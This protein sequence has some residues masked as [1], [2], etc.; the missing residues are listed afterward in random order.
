MS[1]Q[2]LA[3]LR[4]LQPYAPNATGSNGGLTSNYSQSGIGG[5]NSDQWDARGDWQ[6]SGRTHVFGRFSRFTDTLTGTTIFGPAGGAGF[7]LGGYGGTS[8]GANDSAAAG[9]DVALS[10]KWVT[11]VRLG[12][13]RYGITTSKYDQNVAFA[14]QLGIPG[15]NTGSNFTSG[16]PSFGITDANSFGSPGGVQYGS[17][18]GVN[19]CNCALA[20]HEDQYQLANNWTR[21]LGNHSIKFGADLRYAR[22]LR[23]PSDNNRTGELRFG[24]GPTGAGN[25]N[26]GLGLATFVLGDVT[27]F[28]RYASTT[29]NAKEFQKRVFFYAQD[30]WRASAKLTMNYGLRYEMYF[31]EVVNGK[32]N[33]ALLNLA[34]GYLQVA[35]YGSYG[36]NM[37]QS[38]AKNTYNPRIGIAYQINDKTVFRAGYGRSFDIG[39]FG[40]IFGHSAT[41]NLPVL[42]NQSLGNDNATNVAYAFNLATGPTAPPVTSV[43]S[44]GNLPNPGNLVSSRSRPTTL[45]LP[46]LDAWN[47]SLQQSLTPTLSMTIAYVGNKGTH[48]FGDASSNTTNPNESAISLPAAYSVTGQ[49][50]HYDPTVSATTTAGGYLGVAA[51]GGTA[52]QVLLQR[53]YGG[54]LAACSDPAYAA[55][56]GVLAANGGCGWTQ[57]VTYFGD[58]LDTHYNALQATLTKTMAHGI[59]LNANY[60]WQQA[61]SEASGFSTWSRRAVRGN[62]SALRRQQVIVYGLFQLPFGRNKAV[63]GNAKGFVNQ[64][65]SGFEIN[66]VINYSSGLPFTITSNQSGTWVPGSAPGYV[67]G[68]ASNFQ[69]KV[70]GTPNGGLTWYPAATLANNPYGFTAPA[71]DTIG[72]A[73]RNQFFGPHFFNADISVQK[74]FPIRESMA[75]QLR[76]DGLNAFNHINWGTPNG[77]LESGGTITSGAFPNGTSNP[78]Q[79]VFSGRF[80]F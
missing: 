1:S 32:G 41:Q 51:N 37:G 62:D 12:Y 77:T 63:L 16:A 71:L 13:F 54:K 47:A 67:N 50:L 15:L 31:P 10:D 76:A 29:T 56:G 39:V 75:F 35:G 66:P 7:G 25:G 73:G 14:T 64:L 57:G 21:V 70:S 24:T 45:R 3:L 17:G 49:T 44:S 2:A 46:T 33:G 52:Q 72:T 9:V 36:S 6:A 18:L 23:V 27:G 65:V 78:R 42:A 28:Q 4:L 11:D 20:E 61:I 30:T 43:P 79:M 8:L 26:K 38:I 74:N 59:T 60:A 69:K 5:F 80:N 40:S 55:S 68:N 58:D 34:T 19:R 48:T 22:N 53:F